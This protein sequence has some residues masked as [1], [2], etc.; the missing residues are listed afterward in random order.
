[1]VS[2]LLLRLGEVMKWLFG[3][4]FE[5]KVWSKCWCLVEI[6][7]FGIWN[8]I[9]ICVRTCYFGKQYST[10]GSVVPL[11]MFSTVICLTSDVFG[12][13]RIILVSSYLLYIWYILLLISNNYLSIIDMIISL[14]LFGL[15]S[16]MASI[17][18]FLSPEVTF[19]YFIFV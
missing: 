8:L 2:I 16:N 5:V 10:L 19:Y 13:Q 18:T 4:D 12:L 14:G 7:N 6:L 9:K 1:M 3:Q 15:V 17:I 11:A